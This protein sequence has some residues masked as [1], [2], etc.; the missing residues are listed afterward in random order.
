MLFAGLPFATLV[1]IAAVA[2]DEATLAALLALGVAPAAADT[3]DF[4]ETEL[5]EP[6]SL[7]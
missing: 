4:D 6:I 1:T 7:D 2:D 3:D 5:D